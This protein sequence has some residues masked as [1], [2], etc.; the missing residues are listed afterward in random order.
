MSS[1]SSTVSVETEPRPP[2]TPPTVVAPGMTIRTLVPRLAISDLDRG[3][4]AL[5]ETHHGHDRPDADD[6]AQ[7]RQSGTQGI[8][9]QDA[10]SR[11]NREPEKGHIVAFSGQLSALR[12]LNLIASDLADS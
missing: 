10:K 5:A 11:K 8:P 3:R 12:D 1:A 6:D 2:R 4:R 9:A 7:H